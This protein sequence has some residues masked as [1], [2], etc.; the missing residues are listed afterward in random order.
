MSRALCF[1][2]VEVERVS[3]WVGGP[4]VV[5]WAGTADW[6]GGARGGAVGRR[7]G[8]WQVIDR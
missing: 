7:G 2:S 4:F 5:R 3:G 6:G 1:N 8:V